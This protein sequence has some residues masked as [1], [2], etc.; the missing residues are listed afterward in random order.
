[1]ID[2]E[3]LENFIVNCSRGCFNSITRVLLRDIFKIDATNV[4]AKGDG[5][6]DYVV[7]PIAGGAR[8]FV[9]QVTIQ[10]NGW[11]KK[12]LADAQTAV[13]KLDCTRYFFFTSRKHESADLR[14]LEH[15]ISTSYHIPATCLGG[16]E[17]ADMLVSKGLVTEALDALNIPLPST[18]NK[19][20]DRSEILLHSYVALGS[21][22]ADL[23]D[24]VY[25]DTLLITLQ[26]LGPTKVDDL[27][28]EAV[29]SL[30][31]DR[32]RESRLRG[33]IDTLMSRDSISK[34]KDSG[35]VAL[36]PRSRQQLQNAEKI[37]LSELDALA[38]S[39]AA[40]LEREYH[41]EWPPE[42]AQK[43]SVLLAR[44]FIKR[45]LETLEMMQVH[46]NK[47]QLTAGIGDPLQ[48]LRDFISSSGVPVACVNKVL[49]E[50]AEN[51]AGSPLVNKLV[52][53]VLYAALEGQNTLHTARV[54]GV[55]SW[56]QVTVILDASVLIPYICAKLFQPTRGRFSSGAI[57]CIDAFEKVGAKLVTTQEYINEASAHLLKAR[58]FIGLSDADEFL[59]FS[60]NGYV[61]HY[62]QM[63]N[64]EMPVPENLLGFLSK[65]SKSIMREQEQGKWIRSIMADIT[66]LVASYGIQYEHIKMVDAHYSDKIDREYGFIQNERNMDRAGVLFNHDSKTLAYMRK[67]MSQGVNGLICLT[68]DRVMIEVARKVED[69]GWV[70]SPHDAADFINLSTPPTGEKLVSLSHKL[71]GVRERPSEIV[72]ELLDRIVH[73]AKPEQLDWQLRDRLTSLR[74]QLLERVDTTSEEY[75]QWARR[76]TCALLKTFGVGETG[77]APD[78]TGAGA[79]VGSV[80]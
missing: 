55:S 1:M 47:L 61:S 59:A 40:L 75:G 37:Y 8:S 4:D 38:S 65:F 52:R 73:V 50:L 34:D 51:A 77:V 21:E 80:I 35:C 53:G 33:R 25:E 18:S 58:E 20:I 46:V 71:A 41:V 13:N 78:T 29:K 63:R 16:K 30:G 7:I 39:Q 76:E 23:R 15:E 22:T 68:W 42:S 43:C 24:Q 3:T 5:G 36:T 12:A 79:G 49:E 56:D 74:T 10:N 72:G 32:S 11:R 54:L 48:E 44:A 45:N 66:S 6:G 9:A 60:P 14:E 28:A 70:V 17:I 57:Q 31:C 69:C 27:L 62:F 19:R 67:A 26:E 2:K 64:F